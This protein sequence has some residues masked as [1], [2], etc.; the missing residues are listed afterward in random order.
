[1]KRIVCNQTVM[2][3]RKCFALRRNMAWCSSRFSLSVIFLFADQLPSCKLMAVCQIPCKIC[4]PEHNSTTSHPERD[5]KGRWPPCQHGIIGALKQMWV[6]VLVFEQPHLSLQSFD[7]I[8]F[9]SYWNPVCSHATWVE[10]VLNLDC[11]LTSVQQHDW[12]IQLG[13][14]KP[15][16]WGEGRAVGHTTTIPAM[17]LFSIQNALSGLSPRFLTSLVTP[18]QIR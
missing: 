17:A 14:Y 15:R 9:K 5:V 7:I 11:M 1:M 3:A 12:M 4:N 10:T 2:L 16:F 6:Y 18:N 13:G 8:I